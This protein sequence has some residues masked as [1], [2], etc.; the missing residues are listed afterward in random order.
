MAGGLVRIR[1]MDVA[2]KIVRLGFDAPKDVRIERVE[3]R[4]AEG[5]LQSVSKTA[6]IGE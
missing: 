5:N 1:V 3:T 4:D 2:G 6:K